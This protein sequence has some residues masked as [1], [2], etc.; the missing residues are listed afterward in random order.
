[1][2]IPG[3]EML[4]PSGSSSLLALLQLLCREMHGEPNAG[5]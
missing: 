3:H 5:L 4:W 2:N 1:M